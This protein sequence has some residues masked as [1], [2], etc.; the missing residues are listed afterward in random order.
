MYCVA[1]P[2]IWH[3]E[4]VAIL[5]VTARTRIIPT[6]WRLDHKTTVLPLSFDKDQMHHDKERNPVNNQTGGIGYSD[7]FGMRFQ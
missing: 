2:L 1:I 4:F 7:W 6:D 3:A 5:A